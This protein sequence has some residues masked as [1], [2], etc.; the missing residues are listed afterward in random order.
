M[1][2]RKGGFL[3]HAYL[4]HVYVDTPN[5]EDDKIENDKRKVKEKKRKVNEKEKKRKKNRGR[6]CNR[7]CQFCGMCFN[8]SISWEVL[9]IYRLQF[10]CES[11]MGGNNHR[12]VVNCDE[13]KKKWCPRILF[14][15]K[16][17]SA[18]SGGD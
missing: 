1:F 10:Q 16:I 6:G 15:R 14:S 9:S 13:M 18:W 12:L 2:S 3:T 4:S 7:Y 8:N 5:P 17:I 11:E